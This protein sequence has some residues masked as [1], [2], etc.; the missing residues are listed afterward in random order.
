[1]PNEQQAPL[2]TSNGRATA[3]DGRLVVPAGFKVTYYA[4]DVPEV[5]FMAVGPDGAVYASQPGKG[6]IIRLA[7]ANH[8]GIADST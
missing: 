3:L 8:D 2:D 6:R 4:S 7:D 1:M 5:R